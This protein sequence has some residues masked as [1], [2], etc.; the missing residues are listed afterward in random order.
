MEHNRFEFR[1]YLESD[2]DILYEEYIHYACSHIQPYLSGGE[3]GMDK[4]SFEK[5]VRQISRKQHHPPIIA[6]AEGIP[7]GICRIAY[8]HANRYHELTLHLWNHRHITKNVLRE[9]LRRSLHPEE[10]LL[11]E[12]PGYAPELKQAAEELGMDLAGTIPNYLRRDDRL[13]HKYTYL[14]T[15]AKWHSAQN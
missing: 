10:Y 15:S 1:R 4:S 7:C 6:N 2:L 3:I 12:V 9:I 14:I 13:Y 11:M 5:K 8:H